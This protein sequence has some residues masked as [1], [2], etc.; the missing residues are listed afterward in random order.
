M[1]NEGRDLRNK[2]TYYNGGAYCVGGYNF[3]AEAFMAETQEWAQLPDY[4]VCNNLD[5]WSSAMMFSLG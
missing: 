3:K 2:V 5:S 1:M 4:L